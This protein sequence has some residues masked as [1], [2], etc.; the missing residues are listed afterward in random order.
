MNTNTLQ[1]LERTKTTHAF[2]D[3]P[4]LSRSLTYLHKRIQR[5]IIHAA[6]HGRESLAPVG[7][8][9]SA[10]THR[11]RQGALTRTNALAHAPLFYT[12]LTLTRVVAAQWLVRHARASILSYH[13]WERPKEPLTRSSTHLRIYGNQPSARPSIVITGRHGLL[14]FRSVAERAATTSIYRVSDNNYV[15]PCVQ[16]E[17]VKPGRKIL[18]RFAIF[19]IIIEKL[20]NKDRPIHRN[21]S[22]FWK[23]GEN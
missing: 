20:I 4:K 10:S 5:R 2:T 8:H 23:N 16:V 9:V 11:L 15:T 21:N 13:I 12:P 7:W 22:H 17:Q 14:S 3:N 6:W 1:S 18:Y 19:M